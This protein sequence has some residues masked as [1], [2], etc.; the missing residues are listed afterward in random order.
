VGTGNS[1]TDGSG[2]L[3]FYTGNGATHTGPVGISTGNIA[4]SVVPSPTGSTGNID[5]VTGNAAGTGNRSGDIHISTGAVAGGAARGDIILDTGAGPG[6]NQIWIDT[7]QISSHS[8]IWIQT[9]DGAPNSG[10]LG[11]MSGMGVG[12]TSGDAW[13]GTGDTDGANSGMCGFGTGNITGSG[14]SGHI[15]LATGNSSAG[16]SGDINLYMGN[17]PTMG[18]IVLHNY[19]T[20]DPHVAGAIWCDTSAGRVLK[21]SAG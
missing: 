17:A 9:V 6:N 20:A 15:D 19:K 8:Y 4:S 1:E 16:V 14:T 21:V 12:G 13:F 3:L 7:P 11:G 10:G 5:I 2:S 18:N